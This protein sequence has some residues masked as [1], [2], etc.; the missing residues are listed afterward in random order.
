MERVKGEREE[1][2]FR[3]GAG[4]DGV[5]DAEG[6]GAR[7]RKRKEGGGGDDEDSGNDRATDYAYSPYYS[8]PSLDAHGSLI[9]V[10]PPP[11]GCPAPPPFSPAPT[12]I[13][14]VGTTT[15]T[16]KH[17]PCLLTFLTP[18]EVRTATV[19]K[20]RKDHRETT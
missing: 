8:L 11:M 15:C 16:V 9:P 14:M 4:D 17:F 6:R 12:S 20:I 7:K 19:D 18:V 5:E 13:Q 10:Y 1:V 2:R 3:I